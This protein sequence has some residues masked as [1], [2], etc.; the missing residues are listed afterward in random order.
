[1]AGGT[2]IPV[3]VDI[4]NGLQFDID[5]LREKMNPRTKMI[6]LNS[7]NNPSGAVYPKETLMQ[8]A[9]LAQEHDAYLLSVSPKS[10][11]HI[12][13][14]MR[15]TK[16][17]FTMATHVSPASLPGMKQRTLTINGFSKAYAMTGW[18]LVFS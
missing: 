2:P 4:V 14:L 15:S 18:R 11:M 7:P 9:A 5:L 10:T 1:M 12:C 13:S 8:V 3:P 6:V 16:K 17:L